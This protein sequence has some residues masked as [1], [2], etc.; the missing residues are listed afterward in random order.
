MHEVND[1]NVVKECDGSHG[2]IARAMVCVLGVRV[3]VTA[4][5]AYHQLH[6]SAE[7]TPMP[8]TS[9]RTDQS[10]H[11][12]ATQSGPR[13]RSLPPPLRHRETAALH[14]YTE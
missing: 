9:R 5:C 11:P 2:S 8:P 6:G 14:T 4:N 13:R 1:E 10:A 7:Q 3:A 12:V